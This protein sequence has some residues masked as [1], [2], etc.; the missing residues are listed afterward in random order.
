MS[1]QAGEAH[2]FRVG[3]ELH[4]ADE[5]DSGRRVVMVPAQDGTLD[6]L[7]NAAF[8]AGDAN[9][10]AA[11]AVQLD[12][13]TGGTWAGVEIENEALHLRLA[14]AFG[15]LALV[16]TNSQPAAV[17]AEGLRAEARLLVTIRS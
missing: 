4:E 12:F 7:V 16:V 6:L 3:H 1:G 10:D 5:E 15:A 8:T 9:V 14:A 2:V 11:F 13:E 17:E